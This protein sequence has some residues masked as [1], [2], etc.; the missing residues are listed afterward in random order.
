MVIR[1]ILGTDTGDSS[2]VVGIFFQEV[3]KFSFLASKYSLGPSPLDGLEDIV[4]SEVCLDRA[5]MRVKNSVKREPTPATT[6]LVQSWSVPAVIPG[7]LEVCSRVQE[8]LR[9]P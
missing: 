3:L 2:L 9:V 6:E 7:A 8:I 5:R 4:A 1:T